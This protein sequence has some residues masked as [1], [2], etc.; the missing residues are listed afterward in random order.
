MI[1]G[2]RRVSDVRAALDGLREL[3][4]LAAAARAATARELHAQVDAT[5]LS[6]ADASG[7]VGLLE[8]AAPT[9]AEPAQQ[10]AT[11]VVGAAYHPV[12]S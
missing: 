1:E 5:S 11:N 3:P 4:R 2:G 9:D 10:A 6:V 12:N 8:G 7:L